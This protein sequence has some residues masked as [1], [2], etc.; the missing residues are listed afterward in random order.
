MMIINDDNTLM[1]R[2]RTLVMAK[3]ELT[4]EEYA[5]HLESISTAEKVIENRE[6]TKAACYETIEHAL[7]P[8]GISGIEDLLQENV[9]DTIDVCDF[10]LISYSLSLIFNL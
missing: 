3:K 10:F 8:V 2:L 7:I 4:K 5:G 6:E 9:F 1:D